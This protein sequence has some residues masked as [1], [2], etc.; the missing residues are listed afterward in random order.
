MVDVASSIQFVLCFYRINL[1]YF[2]HSDFEVFQ[3]IESDVGVIGDFQFMLS[4]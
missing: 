2:W 3:F 1:K 4:W